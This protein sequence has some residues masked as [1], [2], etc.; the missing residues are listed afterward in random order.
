MSLHSLVFSGFPC[1][2]VFW[3][4]LVDPETQVYFLRDYCMGHCRTSCD[5]EKG[6]DGGGAGRGFRGKRISDHVIGNGT[7]RRSDLRC[8]RKCCVAQKRFSSPPHGADA[9]WATSVSNG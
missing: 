5:E 6:R 1:W 7:A 4:A 2:V 8:Q 3:L 9:G